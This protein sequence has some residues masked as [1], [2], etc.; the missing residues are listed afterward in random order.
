MDI[1][2]F[3][4]PHDYFDQ[5]DIE[6]DFTKA[7]QEAGFQVMAITQEDA[8]LYGDNIPAWFLIK[9]EFGE[10]IAGWTHHGIALEW[11]GVPKAEEKRKEILA[12]FK[13]E[14]RQKDYCAISAADYKKLKE[15][16]TEIIKVISE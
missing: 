5:L 11:S 6:R 8:A 9:T 13:D 16:L 2:S 10:F 4:Y 3:Y 1:K 15:Y 12:K 14:E 7:F